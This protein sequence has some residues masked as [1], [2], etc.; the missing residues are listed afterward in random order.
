MTT[1]HRNEIVVRAGITFVIMT[2]QNGK[3]RVVVFDEPQDNCV[4][5]CVVGEAIVDKTLDFFV[6]IYGNE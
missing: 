2:T 3:R 4:A 6:S 5:D 1:A